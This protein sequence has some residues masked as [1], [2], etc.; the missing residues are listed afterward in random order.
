MDVLALYLFDLSFR[1]V[2]ERRDG[3]A[4]FH[5]SACTLNTPEGDHTVDKTST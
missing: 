1:S 3:A 4:G 5:Y 2:F